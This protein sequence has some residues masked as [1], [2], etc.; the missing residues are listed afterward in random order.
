[1]ENGETEEAVAR[2]V[3]ELQKTSA[4][5][6][7]SSEWSQYQGILYFCGKIYVPDLADLQ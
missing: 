3:E 6:V 5:S 4:C 7:Q 2:A 1:M